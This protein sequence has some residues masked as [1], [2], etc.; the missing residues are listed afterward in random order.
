MAR[1]TQKVPPSVSTVKPQRGK[2]FQMVS[3][4]TGRDPSIGTARSRTRQ[5]ER[6]GSQLRIVMS[7]KK[8]TD[9]GQSTYANGRTIAPVPFHPDEGA[10]TTHWV[11]PGRR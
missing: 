6:M 2:P 7:D 10:A 11:P 3:S 8:T 9:E 1:Q 4:V 5:Y